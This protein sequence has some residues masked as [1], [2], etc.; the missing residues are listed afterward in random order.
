MEAITDCPSIFWDRQRDR[1]RKESITRTH[2]SPSVTVTAVAA[3]DER[4]DRENES[5]AL[6]FVRCSRIQS[7]LSLPF[8]ASL[9]EVAWRGVGGDGVSL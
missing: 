9:K 7:A 1:E 3:T 6:A 4:E 8:L 5:A 2:A